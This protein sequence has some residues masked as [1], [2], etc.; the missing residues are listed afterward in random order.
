[1][2]IRT[3]RLIL[4]PLSEVDQNAVIRIL[5][6]DTVKKTYLLPDFQTEEQAVKLFNVL[7]EYSTSEKH[8]VRGIYLNDK[9]IGFLNDVAFRDGRIELGYVIHPDYH[10]H[11][12]R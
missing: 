5:T 1:M 9:L 12:P 11:G 6:D 10:N 8:Y 7:K 3:E 4:K 2:F